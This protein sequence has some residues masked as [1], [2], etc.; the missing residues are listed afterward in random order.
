MAHTR[1]TVVGDR[2]PPQ[3]EALAQ[4]SSEWRQQ[5]AVAAAAAALH[6]SASSHNLSAAC[7]LILSYRIL[8]LSACTSGRPLTIVKALTAA[9]LALFA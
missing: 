2:V 3:L 9:R 7:S 4:V 6:N 5:A 8:S 1:A